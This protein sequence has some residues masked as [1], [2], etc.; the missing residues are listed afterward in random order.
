MGKDT[1]FVDLETKTNFNEAIYCVNIEEELE[2]KLIDFIHSFNTTYKNFKFK[3]DL[4]Y[5]LKT[6]WI[7]LEHDDAS[8]PDFNVDE[9]LLDIAYQHALIEKVNLIIEHINEGLYDNWRVPNSK[10][11]YKDDDYWVLLTKHVKYGEIEFVALKVDE[12]YEVD[13]EFESY[14]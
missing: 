8:D 10:F 6:V 13:V 9:F 14:I 4:A 11:I 1:Y 7:T 5:N 12:I 3:F 2:D